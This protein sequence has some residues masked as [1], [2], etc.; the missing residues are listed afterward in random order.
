MNV[1][2]KLRL[3]QLLDRL[4]VDVIEAGFPI[5]SEGDFAA[6]Q[7]I[8]ATVRRPTIAGLARACSAD[9]ERGVG[10]S[11]GCDPSA[12]PCVSGDVR[13]PPEVQT[14]NFAAAVS[15]TG[16]GRSAPGKVILRGH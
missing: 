6:V 8:A 13:H 3:A 12:D 15:G 16:P 10:R 7:G 4:G 2:E 1:Q 11:E 9:I 14:S 5:S